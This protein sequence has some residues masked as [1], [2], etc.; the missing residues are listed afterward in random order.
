MV[1]SP[2]AGD[3]KS[4]TAV[5][6]CAAL[7]DS[8]DA[9]LLVE[10]D[11][12][13]PSMHRVLGCNVEPTGIEDVLRGRTNTETA[14]RFVEELGF[15]VAMVS[16]IPRNPSY[17]LAGS[18]CK[19]MIAW[20]RQHF[21][22]V[23]LDTAPVMPNADVAELLPAIDAALLVVRAQITPKELTRRAFDVL[24]KRLHGVVLNE[25]TLSSTPYYRYL[26]DYSH[27]VQSKAV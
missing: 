16:D 23:V 25:A 3:G 7:A 9:T 8:G 11:L 14:I 2:G 13:R 18:A 19:E 1:T 5:N 20:A 15:Y 12:R 22:W 6:L 17:L 24:G 4:L 21:R 27:P 26:S 10:V